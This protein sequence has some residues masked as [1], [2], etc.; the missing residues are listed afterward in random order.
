MPL[1]VILINVQNNILGK[2][3]DNGVDWST[4]KHATVGRSRAILGWFDS[5]GHARFEGTSTPYK[6][7]GGYLNFNQQL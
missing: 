1:K 7:G 2:F 4:Y 3:S 6:N 5:P